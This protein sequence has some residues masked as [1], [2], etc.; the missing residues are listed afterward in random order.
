MKFLSPLFIIIICIACGNNNAD[1]TVGDVDTTQGIYI[2][3]GSLNDSTGEPQVKKV[4]TTEYD[5]LSIP[6]I[7]EMLNQK[8]PQIKLE[9]VK[10]S[11]DTV[12]VAIPQAT[13]LTQ[14]MGS[15]GPQDY[16]INAVYNFTEL[17]G[18]KYVNF[19]MEEGDHAGP[20][21]FT[22]EIVMEW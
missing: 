19:A 17:P 22:R 9:Y 21:V 14:Q 13:Y 11:S 3:Q 7:V 12:Y 15:S 5:S 2:W 10:T 20:G 16:F 18:I 4:K 8:Y 6:I 1:K